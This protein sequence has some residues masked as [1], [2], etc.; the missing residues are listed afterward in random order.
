MNDLIS[1][2]IPVYNGTNYMRQSI[3]SVLRQTYSPVEVLVVD[4]GST[5]RT[6]EIAQSYGDA[7]VFIQ[8]ENGGVATALNTGIERAGGDYVAWLSHDDVF[9]PNKLERQM[10]FLRSNPQFQA[11]YTDY[12]IINADGMITQTIKTPWYPRREA[13]RRLFGQMYINGSTMLIERRCFDIAG[14]FNPNYRYAQD[15]D[16]WIRLLQ[17]FDIGRL[18]EPLTQYRMHGAQ[19]WQS[20]PDFVSDVQNTYNEI[21]E[22]LSVEDLFPELAERKNHPKTLAFR[23][24]WMG[25]RVAKYHQWYDCADRYYA[26][27]VQQWPSWLNLSR[28]KYAVGSKRWWRPYWFLLRCFGKLQHEWRKRFPVQS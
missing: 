1:I 16:M 3:D 10:E 7:I 8:K 27:S 11:S 13:L 4:D 15:A 12:D 18:A 23:H 28:Y 22:R 5:D 19:G 24:A 25:D 17:H 6:A 2:V 21:F 26:R 9:L 14:Y 20:R